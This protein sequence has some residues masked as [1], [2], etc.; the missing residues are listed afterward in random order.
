[1]TET[2]L[3]RPESRMSSRQLSEKRSPTER[4]LLDAAAA[5]LERGGPAAVTTRAVLAEAGLTAPTLYHHFGDKDGLLA[6]LLQEGV[7]DFFTHRDATLKITSDPRS[8]LLAAFDSFLDFVSE[9]PQLFQLLAVRALDDP[10]LLSAA[11]NWCRDR[12]GQLE[13]DGRLEVDAPFAVHALMAVSNGVAM[14]RAQ[15]A[16]DAEV[17]RVGHLIYEQTLSAIIRED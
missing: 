3:L 17:R 7:Q 13:R 9:Q 8:D 16:A 5:L 15:G 14:L 11:V 1:M 10:A 2:A 6:S 12:V 4:S